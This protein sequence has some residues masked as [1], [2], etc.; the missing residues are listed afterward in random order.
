[1]SWMLGICWSGIPR[2]QSL[3]DGVLHGLGAVMVGDRSVPFRDQGLRKE[4][5]EKM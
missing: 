5:Y 4:D 1:M 3:V 2:Y